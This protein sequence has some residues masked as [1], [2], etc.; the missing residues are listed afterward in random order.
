MQ[1]HLIFHRVDRS[2]EQEVELESIKSMV[3]YKHN[4]VSWTDLLIWE[5]SK[6]YERYFFCINAKE[7]FMI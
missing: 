7:I 1:Y 5:L 2:S 4:N 6:R 3:Y